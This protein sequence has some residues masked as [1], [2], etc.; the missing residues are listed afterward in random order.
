MFCCLKT[1]GRELAQKIS[2]AEWRALIRHHAFVAEHGNQAFETFLA[3]L[4]S[5]CQPCLTCATMTIFRT[6]GATCPRGCG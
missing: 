3:Q 1:L 2:L 4:R 6:I 5:G